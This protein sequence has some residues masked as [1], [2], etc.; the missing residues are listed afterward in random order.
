[1]AP[2]TK[3]ENTE[4]SNKYLQYAKKLKDVGKIK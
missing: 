4:N 2:A 3:V 1:M